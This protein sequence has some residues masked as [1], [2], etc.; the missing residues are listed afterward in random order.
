MGANV[1]SRRATSGDVQ[2]ASSQVNAT[3]GDVRLRL[4]GVDL[5]AGGRGF[6]SC[7]PDWSEP[8]FEIISHI[9]CLLWRRT[10]LDVGRR[11]PAGFS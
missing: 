7:H 3:P 2:P 8:F 6:E 10:T 11:R 9:F 1:H 5:G 4:A